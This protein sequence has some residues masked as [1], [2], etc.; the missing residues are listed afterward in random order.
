MSNRTKMLETDVDVSCAVW[1]RYDHLEDTG[2]WTDADKYENI[3]LA[4]TTDKG[5]VA[6]LSKQM[7]AAFGFPDE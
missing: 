6:G 3:N 1:C 2:A 5:I 4:H 7:H